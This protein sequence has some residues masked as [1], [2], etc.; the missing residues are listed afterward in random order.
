MNIKQFLQPLFKIENHR[1][2]A[3]STALIL[4][5]D[6]KDNTFG[7]LTSTDPS[8]GKAYLELLATGTQEADRPLSGGYICTLW[9]FHHPWSHRGYLSQKSSADVTV[10]LFTLAK[11]YWQVGEKDKAI[12][13]LGRSV[14]L[15]QDIFI[16]QHSGISAFKGHG[17]IEQWLADN[18]Q[19]YGVEEGGYYDWQ[20]DFVTATGVGH[21][22]SSQ[23]PYDWIDHGS[24]IS[25]DWFERYFANGKYDEDTFCMLGP[26]I[27]PYV[28][29]FSAG[30]IQR[31]FTEVE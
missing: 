26:L 12:Y 22:V 20:E 5:N 9:H 18:W 15:L 4:R 7:F 30:F 16:P 25:I 29:R 28:L 1:Q 8:T 24:H 21:H 23:N 27:I 13:E 11:T 19:R 17:E 14:H 6:G 10:Q 2:L 3:E 31:F